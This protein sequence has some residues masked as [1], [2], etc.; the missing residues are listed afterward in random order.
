M[1]EFMPGL[2]LA[3]LYYWEAVRPILDAE[4]PALTHSAW[5]IGTGSEVLDFD[6]EMSADHSWGPR[7]ILY[8]SE[9]DHV[10]LADQ[11]R[12]A[13]G[14]RLPFSF[15]GYPTHFEEVADDPDTVLP[16]LTDRRPIEHLVQITTLVSFVR[17][18]TGADLDREL[19]VLDWLT[20]PE[21]KLRTLVSGAVY[22][23]GLNGIKTLPYGVGKIEQCVNS[24]D[25]LSHTAR[26]RKL[27]TL[28]G[29]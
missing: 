20:I 6:T 10:R 18:Y 26:C 14:Y 21:Q 7:V 25:I 13:L 9:E 4:C 12:E 22:R 5:L 24:T 8:F 17:R 11:V 19:T 27:G 29:E 1:S 3:G 16:K 28:Y 23:D 2:E 15:R